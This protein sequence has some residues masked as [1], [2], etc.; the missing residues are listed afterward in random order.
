MPNN[1]FAGGIRWFHMVVVA[2]IAGMSPAWA[3]VIYNYDG[4]WLLD[5]T[6]GLYWQVV[7]VPSSTLQPSTGAIPEFGLVDQLVIDAGIPPLNI[8][9]IT[10]APYSPVLANFLSFFAADAPA[11]PGAPIEF[12]A[13]YQ[14]P[15]D[16]PLG[17]YQYMVFNYAPDPN[18]DDWLFMGT[19][20]VGT[21]GPG[22]CV[23]ASGGCPPTEPAFVYSTVQPT[24]LPATTWLLLSGL[25]LLG[26]RDRV[27]YEG[28]R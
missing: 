18:S 25:T 13:L 22:L 12:G 10:S 27:R 15:P 20:T 8:F 4:N 7:E 24:P 2:W 6:T 11:A 21:Y 26:M 1:S 28:G 3:N 23:G 9:E 5:S 14:Y 19:T 16:R 17:G